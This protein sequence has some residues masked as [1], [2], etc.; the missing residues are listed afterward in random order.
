M[1]VGLT[2]DLEEARKFAS[3]DRQLLKEDVREVITSLE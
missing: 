1:R 2:R 3:P